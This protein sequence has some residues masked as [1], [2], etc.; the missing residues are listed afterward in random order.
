M[1]ACQRNPGSPG[2][3]AF[4]S[5]SCSP[6][7]LPSAPG[8]CLLRAYIQRGSLSLR[9]LRVSRMQS[10]MAPMSFKRSASTRQEL[11]HSG[12]QDAA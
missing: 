2:F 4:R 6:V 5:P 12:E 10:N 8:S 9:V 7:P 3:S 1:L 11:L